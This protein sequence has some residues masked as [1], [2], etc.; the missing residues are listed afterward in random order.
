M[1]SATLALV[2]ASMALMVKTAAGPLEAKRRMAEVM[3]VRYW[4]P[5]SRRRGPWAGA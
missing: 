3:L 1:E 5:A 2:A 4:S